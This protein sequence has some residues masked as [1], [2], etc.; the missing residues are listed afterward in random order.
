MQQKVFISPTGNKVMST[1]FNQRSGYEKQ[2]LFELSRMTSFTS[3]ISV[4][5]YTDDDDDDV[6][7]QKSLHR[8]I[9]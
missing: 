9:P 8:T 4:P 3:K 1:R 5:C 6:P 2:Y 7:Q